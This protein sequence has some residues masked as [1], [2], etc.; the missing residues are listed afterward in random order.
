[1]A[2]DEAIVIKALILDQTITNMEL[3][4]PPGVIGVT[5]SKPGEVCFPDFWR[6]NW[7][8]LRNQWDCFKER[9]LLSTNKL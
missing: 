6:M 7:C 8:E 9:L 5:G 2:A 4:L 1:M 3:L